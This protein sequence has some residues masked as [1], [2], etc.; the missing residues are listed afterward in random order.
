MKVWLDTLADMSTA[1]QNLCANLKRL[2][3]ETPDLPSRA[4]L[5]RRSRV[6]LGTISGLASGKPGSEPSI[7]TVE[8]I[9][10]AYGIEAWELLHPRLG[11]SV[12]EAAWQKKI[13]ALRRVLEDES[14]PPQ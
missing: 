5:S 2:M 10:R 9:A 3:G 11:A 12:S 7:S 14:I 13:I 6:A 1:R 4:A 8:K